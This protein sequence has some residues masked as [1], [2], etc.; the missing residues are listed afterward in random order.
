MITAI[1]LRSKCF[2]EQT[3]VGY[4]GVGA[5]GG[6]YLLGRGPLMIGASTSAQSVPSWCTTTQT[7]S[8]GVADG[9]IIPQ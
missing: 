2:I 6:C 3:F 7:W 1:F 8:Y 5:S 4:N 9:S